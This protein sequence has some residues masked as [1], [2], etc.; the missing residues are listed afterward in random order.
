MARKYNSEGYYDP[1][2]YEATKRIEKHE[3][4]QRYR[5]IVFV[6]SPYSGD[7]VHNIE[8]AR[9]YCRFAVDTNYIP[10]APHLFFTQFLDDTVPAERK[11][12]MFMGKV[13]MGFCREV[14][15]FGDCISKGMTKEI[16]HA[17]RTG[18]R[19]RYFTEEL[20]EK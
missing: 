15:V 20:V 4:K 7:T 19:I 13:L 2:A 10:I 17:E 16:R 18:K 1:T 8:I 12:G 5:P 6:C 3:R 14:W 11:L 9:K